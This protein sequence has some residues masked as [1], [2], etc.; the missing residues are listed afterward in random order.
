M[1]YSLFKQARDLADQLRPIAE[2]I[3]I[4]QSDNATLA[5]ACEV[6]LGLIENN[7]LQ[8]HKK[9]VAARF[10]KAVL[11]EHLVA[12]KLHPKYQ[13]RNLFVGQ[14]HDVHT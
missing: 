13:G 7:L 14:I 9:L 3:D 11:T 12:Y 8:P 10:K 6:W 2:G 5:D 4:T 1:D